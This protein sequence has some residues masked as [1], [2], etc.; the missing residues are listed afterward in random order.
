MAYQIDFTASN[1][2]S[3]SRRKACLRL[4][5]LASAAGL[6]WGAHD[7]Y[8]TY[9][10]PTLNMRLAEYEAVARPIEE[11]SAA[12]D[13]AAKEYAEMLRYY[14]LLWAANPTN[15]LAAMAS[16]DAPSLGR[17]SRP[18]NWTLTTGGDCRLDFHYVFSAGNK[19]EQTKG[20]EQ[21]IANAVTTLVAVADNKVDVQG[22][23]HENL[24][25][26]NGF[27]LSV[28]F[29]L[30]GVKTFPNKE[31][32]LADCVAEIARMRKTVQE[33]KVEDTSRK[34]AP[35]KAVMGVMT[36]YIPTGRDKPG[37]PDMK[38]V[39]D[40]GGWFGRADQFIAKNRIPGNEQDRLKIKAAWNEIGEARFPWDRYRVLDNEAFVRRTKELETVSDGVKRFKGFLEK[41]Q[42]DCRKKLEPFVEAYEH[43]KIFN[44]H[45]VKEDLE[46]RVAHAVGITRAWVPDPQP[47]DEIRDAPAVL[48]KDDETF[49]FTWIRWT[50]SI[51]DAIGRDGD[52]QRQSGETGADNPITPEVLM[53]CIRRALA[54]GPGYA[55]EKVK[56]AFGADESISG[57]VMEGLLPVK[58]VEATKKETR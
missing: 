50:L 33:V 55:L 26:V 25:S 36:A 51:G 42:A 39:I 53:A 8:V 20:L 49:T 45:L 47:Q 3:R 5:L 27:D 40:V 37:F 18:L 10:L 24:L 21:E 46:N 29:A 17:G 23:P 57:V 43:R 41:R 14:R 48:V 4:A 34:G 58:K 6:V 12:W 2:V 31:K 13:T 28:R 56:I 32:T 7:V 15:L 38:N 52:R 35:P 44:E 1:Y 30:P 22:V 16:P 19:A 9:N 11:M 54:L